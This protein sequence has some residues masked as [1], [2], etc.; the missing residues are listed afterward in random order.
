MMVGWCLV[1]GV[2][3]SS[4]SE[5]HWTFNFIH[6]VRSQW[7]VFPAC[8]SL[9]FF[10][11]YFLLLMTW[12][13]SE[14]NTHI[15]FLIWLGCVWM[16]GK[17]VENERNACNPNYHWMKKLGNCLMG[18]KKVGK[19]RGKERVRWNEWKNNGK[20]CKLLLRLQKMN[21]VFFG[22]LSLYWIQKV[23]VWILCVRAVA[24]NCSSTLSID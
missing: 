3:T 16:M 19:V 5:R 1:A 18:A 6:F 20:Y 14:T 11:R 9:R 8:Q 12:V 23:I 24:I 21:D 13:L 2:A 4:S 22:S 15:F 10:L 7:F 17:K